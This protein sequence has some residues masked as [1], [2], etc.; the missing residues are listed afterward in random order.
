MTRASCS[1]R[2]SPLC[3]SFSRGTTA[4][5][6]KHC[7]M[8]SPAS[9]RWSRS[10]TAHNCPRTT[11]RSSSTVATYRTSGSLPWLG[12]QMDSPQL[13]SEHGFESKQDHGI[14]DNRY[15]SQRPEDSAV[16][17]NPLSHRKEHERQDRQNKA[18]NIQRS[19]VKIVTDEKHRIGAAE[20]PLYRR[21]LTRATR[22][23]QQNCSADSRK[24]PNQPQNCGRPRAPAIVQVIEALQEPERGERQDSS[25][26]E[27][28]VVHLPI[29]T[30]KSGLHEH[31]SRD[32]VYRDQVDGSCGKSDDATAR[33]GAPVTLPEQAREQRERHQNADGAHDRRRA[34]EKNRQKP[35]FT[36][37]DQ[38]RGK[39][40]GHEQR[41]ASTEHGKQNPS[42]ADHP[43][44]HSYKPS[45]EPV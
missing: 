14:K 33:R 31:I 1:L 6:R 42:G 4:A 20:Y 21:K 7:T 25:V 23:P 15:R 12:C 11:N 19:I 18:W 29:R 41:L 2:I 26:R 34:S 39:Q 24:D 37:R 43:E 9:R 27:R 3:W 45:I 35:S 22:G 17:G 38:K 5:K 32:Q 36:A 30:V 8:Q 40:Q 13:E 16:L 44:D 28:K 10:T